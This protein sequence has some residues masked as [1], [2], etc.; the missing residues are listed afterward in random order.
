LQEA[1]A[2]PELNDAICAA[3]KQS[4]LVPQDL[5]YTQGDM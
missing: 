4:A 1:G 5:P 3:M 2:A